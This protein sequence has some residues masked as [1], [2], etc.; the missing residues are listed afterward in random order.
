MP[1]V[2]TMAA[3]SA[4]CQSCRPT[5]AHA[6]S[7]EQNAAD[8]AQ[9]M[10]ERQD[11]AD[12]LRPMRHAAERKHEAGEQDRRQEEE[13]RHLHRLQLVLRDRREG[14]AH[15]EVG[16]DEDERDD[17]QQRDA[18]QHRHVEEKVARRRE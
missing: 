7:F 12:D 9:E 3:K 4:I 8:D 16:G 10:R 6:I 5:S 18:A 15:R 14:D 11:F 17:Q 13:E 1:M 2:S